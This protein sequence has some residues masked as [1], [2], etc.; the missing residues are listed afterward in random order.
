MI[1]PDK[2]I[3]EYRVTEKATELTSELNQYTFEVYPSANRTQVA[4]AIQELF[5]VK[6]ARVNIMNKPGKTKRSRNNRGRAGKTAA[7]KKAI[8]TLKAGDSIELV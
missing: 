1:S 3:K 2:I 6:V 5:S 8:V 4:L 7:I